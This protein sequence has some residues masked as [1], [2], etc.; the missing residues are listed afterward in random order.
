MKKIMS[1][2]L[3]VMTVISLFAVSAFAAEGK[4]YNLRVLTFEDED[5]KGSGN[6]VTAKDWSTL[7]DDPQ[8]GGLLLYGEE[9]YGIYNKEDN[10]RWNGTTKTTHSLQ[11]KCVQPMALMHIGAAAM[12]FPIMFPAKLLNTATIT[13]SLPFIRRI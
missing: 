13:T 4:D 11:A 2:L 5:Y 10:Y 6:Y 12:L 1:M 8:Y 7:I 3:A 9:G